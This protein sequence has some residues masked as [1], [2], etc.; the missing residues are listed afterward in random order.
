MNITGDQM[1]YFIGQKLTCHPVQIFVY[2]FE[3]YEAAMKHHS[4]LKETALPDEI[5][6]IPFFAWSE[7]NAREKVKEIHLV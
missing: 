6:T 3:N 2:S 1:A 7:E 4:R 5:F